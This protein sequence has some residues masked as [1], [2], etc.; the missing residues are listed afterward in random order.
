M[1]LVAIQ[2]G[3]L[4]KI[5]HFLEIE[6]Q[7]ENLKLTFFRGLNYIFGALSTAN[8]AIWPEYDVSGIHKRHFKNPFNRL[9]AKALG[10]KYVP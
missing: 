9:F 2:S 5:M 8:E 3:C 4:R 6:P 10:V 1:V 7:L